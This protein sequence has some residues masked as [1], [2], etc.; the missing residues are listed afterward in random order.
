MKILFPDS[1][2]ETI[3]ALKYKAFTLKASCDAIVDIPKPQEKRL[4]QLEDFYEEIYETLSK[5]TP[6]SSVHR[7][8]RK[9]TFADDLSTLE[10]EFDLIMATLDTLVKDSRI[11]QDLPSELLFLGLYEQGLFPPKKD[12]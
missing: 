8:V 10:Q 3:Q 1:Y 2:K 6:K 5:H 12:D 9:G 11:R 7:M 4:D